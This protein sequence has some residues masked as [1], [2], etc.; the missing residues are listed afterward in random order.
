MY[1]ELQAALARRN[2]LSEIQPDCASPVF[3]SPKLD[4]RPAAA[5]SSSSKQETDEV[6]PLAFALAMAS[7]RLVRPPA[8]PPQEP[9][10][11]QVE[12]KAMLL[13]QEINAS[14]ASELYPEAALVQVAASDSSD[15]E[16]E[17]EDELFLSLKLASSLLGDG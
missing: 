13:E 10:L 4:Q 6:T 7:A 5:S 8:P 15:P 2:S 1:S 3:H 16:P 14:K 12:A 11:E 17:F 9:L